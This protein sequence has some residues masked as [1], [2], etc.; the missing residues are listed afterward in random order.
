MRTD[1][2]FAR[3]DDA[4]NKAVAARAMDRTLVEMGNSKTPLPWTDPVKTQH[5]RRES[6]TVYSF[7]GI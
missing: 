2:F 5:M 3:A 6:D 1:V 7:R 4:E